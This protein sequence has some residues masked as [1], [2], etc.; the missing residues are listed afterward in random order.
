[1]I[2]YSVSP[3]PM[4]ISS[5]DITQIN[6]MASDAHDSRC[7]GGISDRHCAVIPNVVFWPVEQPRF[8]I[9]WCHFK[10][11]SSGMTIGEV[12][13]TIADRC[14]AVVWRGQVDHLT[15]AGE[16]CPRSC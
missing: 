5:D 6:L 3:A 4:T 2:I 1:M 8:G 9:V 14:M 7:H 16:I 11:S 13:M 10:P 12:C 15:A